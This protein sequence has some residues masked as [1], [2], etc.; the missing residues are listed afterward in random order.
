M[1]RNNYFTPFQGV[2]R[3]DTD[4]GYAAEAQLREILKERYRA[5]TQSRTAAAVELL[6][7]TTKFNGPRVREM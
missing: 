1:Q 4:R 5:M 7:A 3:H 2:A 6:V